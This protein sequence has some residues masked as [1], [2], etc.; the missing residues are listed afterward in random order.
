[1]ALA[2]RGSVRSVPAGDGMLVL[3]PALIGRDLH[4]GIQVG[5]AAL[6]CAGGLPLPFPAPCPPAPLYGMTLLPAAALALRLCCM[7]LAAICP[8]DL[9]ILDMMLLLPLLP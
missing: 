9:G 8:A 7:C 6:A 1:M 2:I 5:E 4:Q 3:A